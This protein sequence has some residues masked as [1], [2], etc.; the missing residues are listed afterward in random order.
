MSPLLAVFQIGQPVIN[1]F[2]LFFDDRHPL[3]K[4]I[5]FLYFMCKCFDLRVRDCLRGLHLVHGLS[6]ADYNR[7]DGTGQ[8]ADPC[9][10]CY[11]Y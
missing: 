11:D 7:D 5:V 10:N 3:C 9:Y 4:L 1:H 2:D 6:V 8:R